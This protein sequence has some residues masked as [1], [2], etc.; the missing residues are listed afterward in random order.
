MGYVLRSSLSL[1]F[2]AQTDKYDQVYKRWIKNHI[3]Y[4][5]YSYIIQGD[6]T[7]DIYTIATAEFE[8]GDFRLLAGHFSLILDICFSPNQSQIISA[9]RDEKIRVSKFPHAYC[10]DSFLLGH[11]VCLLFLNIKEF[12]SK[13]HVPKFAPELC[14]SGGGDAFMILW[15]YV[16][17]V[18]VD[19]FDLPEIKEEETALKDALYSAVLD[20]Q[21]CSSSNVIAVVLEK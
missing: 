15:D 10:I 3:R 14:I 1:Y 8:K 12:V 20:I 9:E 17:G 13:V 5:N 18:E 7:G 16:S 4:L 6:K 19:R 21:S 11:K 2:V